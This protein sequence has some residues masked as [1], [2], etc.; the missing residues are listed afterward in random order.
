M[1]EG[2]VVRGNLV[3]MFEGS[4]AEDKFLASDAGREKRSSKKPRSWVD[5]LRNK[6]FLF[7]VFGLRG[8]N[9][10]LIGGCVF[11][12]LFLVVDFHR[13]G[14][15][16]RGRIMKI[17]SGDDTLSV[18]K[19]EYPVFG[20]S[21]KESIAAAG[22]RNI[23]SFASLGG[24]EAQ[25]R[26]EKS[27]SD[28]LVNLKLVGVFWS[29]SNPQVLIENTQ[30]KKTVLLSPGDYLSDLVRVKQIYRDKVVIEAE[31]EEWELR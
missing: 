3:K 1:K 28:I 30:D 8:V 18:R 15:K 24:G 29:E 5:L 4:G 10:A 9:N 19:K 22:K 11:L 21:L 7:G 27:I 14:A 26:P 16:L 25:A 12:T 31:G 23:F 13:Q 20:V 17:M 2:S 6:R